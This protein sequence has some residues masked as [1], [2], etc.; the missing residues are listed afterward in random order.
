MQKTL[1]AAKT[2][3]WYALRYVG[4]AN[5]S[6]VPPLVNGR[7]ASLYNN[8][9]SSGNRVVCVERVESFRLSLR[10][11]KSDTRR[12]GQS[13]GLGE[14]REPQCG[15]VPPSEQGL[16]IAALERRRPVDPPAE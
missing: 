5:M 7:F 4:S 13:P 8:G 3:L 11:H 2:P 14:A 1:A 10:H 15:V 12:R 6:L 9:Q 16:V